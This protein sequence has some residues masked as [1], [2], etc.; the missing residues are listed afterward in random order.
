MK[1]AVLDY[2]IGN[3]LTLAKLLESAG[4]QVMI[5]TEPVPALT[6]NAL[7]LPAVGAFGPAAKVLADFAPALRA[8]LASGHPCLGIGL[9]MQLLFEGNHER[10]GSGIAALRGGVRRLKGKRVP[11]VGWNDVATSDDPLFHGMLPFL[12]YF[13]HSLVVEPADDSCTLAW[14]E[15]DD[16]RF[17]SVV[18]RDRTWGVQFRPEKSGAAGLTVIRNFLRAAQD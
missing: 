10:E 9:G 11:H 5:E 13:D 2:G 16:D 15:N 8:A 3:L 17:P 1:V 4:A 7:V 12:A 18:R 14:I 6:A